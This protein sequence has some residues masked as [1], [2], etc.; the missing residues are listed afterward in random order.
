MHDATLFCDQ[1][2]DSKKN[3]KAVQPHGKR[4]GSF[5]NSRLEGAPGRLFMFSDSVAGYSHGF[6][7]VFVDRHPGKTR[8]SQMNMAIKREIKGKQAVCQVFTPGGKNESNR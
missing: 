6:L 2:S 3:R 7:R 1:V 4:S 5:P 8:V